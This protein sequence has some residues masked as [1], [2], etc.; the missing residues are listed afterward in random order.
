MAI[1][2]PVVS[3]VASLVKTGISQAGAGGQSLD[4]AIRALFANGEQGIWLDPSDFSTMFQDSLGTT[5]VTAVEQPVGLALDKRLGLVRG[6]EC[7]VNGTFDADTAWT[8]GSGWTINGGLASVDTSTQVFLSQNT[9]GTAAGWYEISM[10]VVSRTSGEV[11]VSL[12]GATGIIT[13]SI[14]AKRAIV[15]VPAANFA[16]NIFTVGTTVLSVDNISVRALPGN[17]AS[18]TTAASRPVLSARKNKLLATATLATQSVTLTASAHTLSF[19]GT[20]TVTLSGASTA[21]P[22]VGTG[23][24]NRVSL[25]FTPTAGSVTFTVSGSVTDAQLE[26]GSA[27]TA[28]QRVTTATDYDTVGFPHY[29]KYDLVDDNLFTASIDFTGTDKMTAVSAVQSTNTTAGTIVE[30]GLGGESQ[31]FWLQSANISGAGASSTVSGATGNTGYRASFDLSAKAVLSSQMD[32]AAAA[33]ADKVNL[34][35]NGTVPTLAAVGTSATVAAGFRTGP[36][37][38]GRRGGVNTP[39]GGNL[40]QLIVRGAATPL[41]GIQA[42]EAYMAAKMGVTL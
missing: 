28:Y 23:A 39:F 33:N 27:A 4:S 13:S 34:R 21:G 12:A 16:I 6:T 9:S 25:T 37:H 41:D 32:I 17:H 30:L 11:R 24:S 20:G 19:K 40:Y 36:I 38:I 35:V 18:Q 7:A 31:A 14:G 42:A 1:V 26:N 2:T 3:K 5:P 10:D 15:F 29:L 22:L 8:K